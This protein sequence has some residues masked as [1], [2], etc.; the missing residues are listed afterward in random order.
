M[1]TKPK[2]MK[3][4]VESVETG[5]K[6]YGFVEKMN[7]KGPRN[8]CLFKIKKNKSECIAK[9]NW[10]Q[11]WSGLVGMPVPIEISGEKFIFSRDFGEIQKEVIG[12][13]YIFGESP[14]GKV[15]SHKELL[16]KIN[17][18]YFFFYREPNYKNK[19]HFL[20]RSVAKKLVYNPVYFKQKIKIDGEKREICLINKCVDNNAT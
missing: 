12:E 13:L 18:V 3:V 8:Y 17:G 2:E 15:V 14:Q 19:V 6:F 16:F 4:L 11:T 1:K 10:D 7:L 20:K 9:L 5:K